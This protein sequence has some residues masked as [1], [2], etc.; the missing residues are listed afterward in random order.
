MH[1]RAR[2]QLNNGNL[3]AIVKPGGGSLKAWGYISA[4]GVGDLVRING[5][6][7]AKKDIYIH[8]AILSGGI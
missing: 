6:L 4:N 5:F 7:K 3:Q 1:Y 8:H 2:E